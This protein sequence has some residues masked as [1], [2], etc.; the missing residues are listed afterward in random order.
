MHSV[1]RERENNYSAR[2]H[3]VLV[4]GERR[5]VEAQGVGLEGGIVDRPVD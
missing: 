1:T 4:G 3:G 2:S 5:V